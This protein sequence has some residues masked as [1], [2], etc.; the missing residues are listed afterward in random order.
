MDFS[1]S[2]LVS[3]SSMRSNLRTSFVALTIPPCVVICRDKNGTI[4]SFPPDGKTTFGSTDRNFTVS[5]FYMIIVGCLVFTEK[6]K[7]HRYSQNVVVILKKYL[8]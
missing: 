7:K 3:F 2:F 1:V 5:L 6:Q 8:N 4:V